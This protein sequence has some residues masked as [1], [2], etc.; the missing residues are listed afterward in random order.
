MDIVVLVKQVP[1]TESLIQ[2]SGDGLSIK[3]DT[4]KWVMNPYDEL[5]VEEAIK[6]R[7]AH[8]GTVT[9]VSVGTEQSV[10][11]LRTALA[12]GA[13]KAVVVTDTLA[14]GSDS[15]GTARILSAVIKEMPHDLIIAGQRAVDEDSY[16]VGA[17]VSS[18]NRKFQIAVSDV[19]ELLKALSK[20]LNLH[21]LPF[22]QLNGDLMNPGT[23]PCRE[24]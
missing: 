11:T 17:A 8:G 16:Q 1:D 5:A 22:L 13:D 4:I 9:I 20:W 18:S 23:L 14:Q 15:L 10:K 2:I 7:E 6:I 12:M 19:I 24:L 21:C 3:T